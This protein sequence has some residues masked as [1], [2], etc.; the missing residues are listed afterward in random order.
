MRKAKHYLK[1]AIVNWP[2]L[3]ILIA[4]LLLRLLYLILNNPLT[5]DEAIYI[6]LAQNLKETGKFQLD[7]LTSHIIPIENLPRKVFIYQPIYPIILTI[8]SF[9]KTDISYLHA[10][11]ISIVAGTLTVAVTYLISRELFNK[12]ISY[13][14]ALQ[15]SFVPFLAFSSA[16]A[17][18]DSLVYLFFSIFVLY[19]IK[20]ISRPNHKYIYISGIFIILAYLTR[21]DFII[22]APL[23]LLIT[24]MD[25]GYEIKKSS[26]FVFLI[27]FTLAFL[28]F[29]SI[30][31]PQYQSLISDPLMSTTI[32]INDKSELEPTKITNL[33]IDQFKS[34]I[35]ENTKNILK[36]LFIICGIFLLGLLYA[37]YKQRYRIKEISILLM[38]LSLH[39]LFFI[40][41]SPVRELRYQ[42]YIVIPVFI[43]CG[44]MYKNINKERLKYLAMIILALIFILQY[45]PYF[46]IQTFEFSPQFGPYRLGSNEIKELG[47]SG[48]LKNNLRIMTVNI[49]LCYYINCKA[50]E[51]PYAD[52]KETK[53]II[54]KFNISHVI[55]KKRK[56]QRVS[57]EL[58]ETFINSSSFKKDRYNNILIFT[59]N[60][61]NS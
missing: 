55:F 53:E 60:M 46:H 56:D 34:S 28:V 48:H 33:K 45:S 3:T 30:P 2:I 40:I 15:I 38:I 9:L 37:I 49:E 57:Q 14:I 26:I 61:Q 12:K 29:L 7:Y 31:F 52:I 6:N 51:P 36:N 50:V 41:Y 1:L 27:T 20:G 8:T 5:H 11:I 35:I 42:Y 23:Y 17:N 16:V 22:F 19:I 21:Q 18:T 10:R 43:L 32:D 4:A 59:K 24:F 44:F 54:N 39:I 47:E 25:T 13:I 58:K